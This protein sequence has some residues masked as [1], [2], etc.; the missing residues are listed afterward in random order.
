MSVPVF[1]RLRL[2][3]APLLAGLLFAGCATQPREPV[4]PVPQPPV[5][6]VHPY[7]VSSPSGTRIDNYYWLRDDTRSKPEVLNYLKAENAYYAQ[8]TQHTQALQETL[9]KEIAARLAP[10]DASVPVKYR[11]CWYQTRYAQGAEYPVY[12]RRCGKPDGHEEVMLDGPVLAK[13]HDFFQIGQYEISPN[14]KLAAYAEDTA[15]RQQFTIRIKDLVSGKILPDELK[16]TPG[17]MAWADDNRTLF[18]V[19]NDPITLLTVRVKKHTLGTDPKK[20][21]VVYEERDHSYYLD[22]A[23]TGDD[24][25]IAIESQSTLSSEIR[26]IP[27]SQPKARFKVLAP[28]EHDLEYHAEHIDRRWVIRTNWQAKNYRVMQVDDAQAGDKKRWREIV[29][30]RNDATVDRIALF[31]DYLVIGEHSEG[32]AR[33]R[34]KPWREGAS[35]LVDVAEADYAATIGDNR[36]PNT[37]V[38]RYNV[39]SLVTPNTVYDLDMRTGKRE[40]RKRE[41]V[42]GY[43]AANYTTE[44]VW[45]VA[46]DGVKVPVSVAWRKDLKRDGSA[47]M[48]QIGYGSYGAQN[49]PR[50]S[51]AY[52][53]LLDR[54]F[55]VSLAHIRG[56]GELGRSWYEDGKLLKKKNTFTDFIDTTEYLVAQK[57][58]AKDKVFAFGRSAGGLLMGAIA[59]MAPQDYRGIFTQVPFVDVVTTMLDDSI[60]LTT[61]EYDEW[62]NPQD[63]KFYEYMLAYSPYDNVKAQNYPAMLVTTGLNE[64]QVQ[65][66]EPS[67][68]VAKL[69]A[70]K[71]DK[72]PLLFKIN[73]EAGHG[74]KSGRYTHWRETAEAYAFMLDQLPAPAKTTK[75]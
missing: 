59:N 62:G 45:A 9:Y 63:T 27:A 74:G 40:E 38:L 18:Y 37:D 55:V 15:G 61:N 25:F 69:R 14:E 48:L 49:D 34:I 31:R 5:A 33:V 42:V 23:R 35:R 75:K 64:S 7:P 17:A 16:N 28:R 71:T 29:P 12:L 72:N 41:A 65:Y 11:H 68:W 13:G 66:Y 57:Y 47:P 26:F 8:M 58:A 54:G 52:V 2:R 53:S 20:D 67:K 36:E 4:Q 32:L 70:T 1:F 21:T 50:F 10:D 73:M 46:R 39:T 24:K 44:R 22:I 51:P 43:D 30:A 60:P 6:A 56:G 3:A 19:E